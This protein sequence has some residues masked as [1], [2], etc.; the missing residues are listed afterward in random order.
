M[1]QNTL[2]DEIERVE[3]PF[4]AEPPPIHS[5]YSEETQRA[6]L[7]GRVV[8]PFGYVGITF[9]K[10]TMTQELSSEIE[11]IVD[12]FLKR[13]ELIRQAH[14][15]DPYMGYYPE[16]VV[17]SELRDGLRHIAEKTVEAVRVEKIKVCGCPPFQ[18][19][20][21][22]YC[23]SPDPGWEQYNQAVTKQNKRASAWLGK[24][25]V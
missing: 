24:D 13:C 21:D 18:S 7:C 11:R 22:G 4:M 12:G 25:N 19:T 5:H 2:S 10:T 20:H 17:L 3:N 6:E 1:T 9:N 8:C 23:S 16:D 14:K 15:G